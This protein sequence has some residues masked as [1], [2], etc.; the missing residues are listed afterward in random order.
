MVFTLRYHGNDDDSAD[1][2]EKEKK[3]LQLSL[4]KGKVGVAGN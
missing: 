3:C 4:F 1:K 2:K